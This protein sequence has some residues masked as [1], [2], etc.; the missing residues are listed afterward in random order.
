MHEHS[1]LPSFTAFAYYLD[2]CSNR[3]KE[4]EEKEEEKEEKG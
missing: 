4:E 1:F 3:L 2:S